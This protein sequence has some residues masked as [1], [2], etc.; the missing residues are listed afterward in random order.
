[1]TVH[2]SEPGAAADLRRRAVTRLGGGSEATAAQRGTVQRGP[3][4][5]LAVL[6]ELASSPTTAADALALLHEIQVH[7]V[8]LEM[9]AEELRRSR[10]ELE[11]CLMRQLQLFDFSPAALY[12][13]DRGTVLHEINL[14]GARLLGAER[15]T[16]SGRALD[17]F[18]APASGPA[19]HAM[20][21]DIIDG[22]GEQVRELQISLP[23]DVRRSVTVTASA[24]PVGGLF[25]LVLMSVAQPRAVPA[26]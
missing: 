15:D 2:D 3:I 11:A 8:E 20:L 17:G 1:M 16:L 13:V 18:L 5:A 10:A 24:D 19:L 9:Q 7:Q 22:K 26:V 21:A 12:S 14:A 23:G 4:D 25:L 6:F